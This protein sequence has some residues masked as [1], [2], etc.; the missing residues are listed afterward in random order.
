MHRVKRKMA[1]TWGLTAL[2][3]VAALFAASPTR[4]SLITFNPSGNGT[5]SGAVNN[6][7][8][9]SYAT[10]NVAAQG[11]ANPLNGGSF[12]IYYQSTL[13]G[14]K[15]IRANGSTGPVGASQLVASGMDF[16]VVAGFKEMISGTSI[17]AGGGSNR[18]GPG[19]TGGSADALNISFSDASA[20]GLSTAPG[21]P[22]FFKIY[23]VPT[24]TTD[25]ALGTGFENLTPILT[26]HVV[27]SGFS[28]T[29][30]EDGQIVGGNFIPHTEQFNQSGIASPLT[31]GTVNS[32]V[33]SGG[34]NIRIAIDSQDL[35]YFPTKLYFLDFTT[36]NTQPYVSV[37]PTSAFYNGTGVG[38]NVV[39]NYGTTNG[40]S[41]PDLG[42]QSVA[43]NSFT[44]A[45]PE[46]GSFALAA[47]SLV[48]TS[49]LVLRTRRNRKTVVQA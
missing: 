28:G 22:N 5:G 46:P 27:A 12:N 17:V 43:N 13:D 24:L 11:I 44:S 42:F 32:V 39:V 33:G 37:P 40:V 4:A 45:V 8:S 1:N 3:A 20:S 9:F 25:D 31:T 18:Q 14:I 49:G 41:G 10:G 38:P 21:N 47:S 29:F 30:K 7:V 19:S 34:T 6:V 15:G 2:A 23:A 26:G 35:S 48:L 16:S 36:T